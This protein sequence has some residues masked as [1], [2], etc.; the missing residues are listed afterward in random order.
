[1]ALGNAQVFAAAENGVMVFDRND[2]SITS[3]SKLNG[4]NGSGITWINYDNTTRQVLIGY[5]EGKLDVIQDN[6]VTG[7]DPTQGSAITGSKK[8]NH[9]SIQGNYAYLS[10]DYGVVVFDLAG[11]AIKE[12][13][14][15]LGNTGQTLQIF[16][17]TFKGDSVFL[18]TETGVIAGDMDDNLL[19]FNKWKRFSGGD[20]NTSI[21]SITLFDNKVY[22]PV[23]GSGI[24]SY[25]DGVWTL[26]AFLSG[27]SFHSLSSSATHLFIIEKTNFSGSNVNLWKKSAA[28]APELVSDEQISYANYA[29]EDA[30]GKLWIGDDNNGLVSN[31]TGGFL[32]LAANGPSSAETFRM[33]YSFER[34]FNMS[35]GYSSAMTP[36]NRAGVLDEFKDGLWYSELTT[37]NDIT[38][39]EIDP[40][41]SQVI[42]SYG[43]GLR[44]LDTDGT[45]THYD[46]S[47]STLPN[48]NIT[49]LASSWE[50]IWIAHYG[51]SQS[52]TLLNS[53]NTF[54]SFSALTTPGRYPLDIVEDLFGNVWMMVNPAQ[55]GGL[56]VYS[57]DQNAFAYLTEN[58]NNGALP[59][60]NVRSIIVDRDGLVW[61]GTDLGVC[62]FYSPNE[63]AIKPIFESRF[64]LRD[65]KVTAIAVD[66]GNR[67]WMGTER[68]VWLFNAIGEEM[69][70]N[71]TTENSPLLS[72]VIRDIEIDGKTGEVFFITDKGISSFRSDATD[73][74]STQ[75]IKIF[76]NPVLRTFSGT[77]GISGLATDAE[78]K[79]TDISGK[80]VWQ[81]QAQGGTASWNV[82]DYNGR[83]A[84]TG[85]YLVF[86][87][88]PDGRESQVGKIAVVD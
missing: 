52:L 40:S 23:D 70:Y 37:L 17:S 66:G 36:L 75:K 33:K 83:R 13:W 62:Y 72:N 76:P 54:T 44:K 88:T 59:N 56:Y 64:L 71:F 21:K 2:Q 11:K 16:Q 8:I 47:N 25:L 77:V 19:D 12:T 73:G 6:V 85:I 61:V 87:A 32:S 15:D 69:I 22:V 34:M 63:N 82:Q 31:F 9:I 48:N 42:S 43:S 18:A 86:S 55:G 10:T 79:I 81:S 1:M 5:E 45:V 4:L 38:D 67:K 35:G 65:D 24:Y 30:G 60:K 3:Y 84:S 39:V 41:G 28:G 80:L 78:V 50:G 51:A 68:G 57:K 74:G 27:Q 14:R 7:I 58:Q 53:D 20:L 46:N 26:E 49:A 29:T